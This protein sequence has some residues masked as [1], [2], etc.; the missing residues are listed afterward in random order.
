LNVVANRCQLLRT[1]Q[2]FTGD[3]S[4]CPRSHEARS[5]LATYSV[6]AFSS[7]NN[8]FFTLKINYL[9][10]FV[11]FELIFVVTLWIRK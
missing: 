5:E 8:H 2:A 3:F 4:C 6:Y 9:H 11:V 1:I 7:Q 10:N